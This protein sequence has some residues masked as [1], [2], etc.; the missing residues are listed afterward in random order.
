[1][2]RVFQRFST[3]K[4]SRAMTQFTP[5]P[6]NRSSGARKVFEADVGIKG[7]VADYM[8]RGGKSVKLQR[9][10]DNVERGDG[11]RTSERAGDREQQTRS[12]E[13]GGSG[14]RRADD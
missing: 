2:P 3:L 14:A 11:G 10:V 12:E 13:F 7:F 4:G 8:G 9:P 5:L 6:R 1:M